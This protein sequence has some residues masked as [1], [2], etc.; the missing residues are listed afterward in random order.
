[1][2]ALRTEVKTHN[3]IIASWKGA[4]QPLLH[5]IAERRITK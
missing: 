2:Q 3:S 4:I 1:M 5:Y